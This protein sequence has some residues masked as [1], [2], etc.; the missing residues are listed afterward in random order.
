M[1]S[2]DDDD[3]E[4]RD[5]SEKDPEDYGEK[6]RQLTRRFKPAFSEIDP[7]DRSQRS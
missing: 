5:D 3:T 4:E 6:T 7:Y 2:E 1:P